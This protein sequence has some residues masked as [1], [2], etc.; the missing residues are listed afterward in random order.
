MTPSRPVRDLVVV[1]LLLLPLTAVLVEVF[2]LLSGVIGFQRDLSDF[3]ATTASVV[4]GLSGFER[5]R[6]PT[7]L[8]VLL[9]VLGY[10]FVLARI[11]YAVGP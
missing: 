6:R 7:R 4:L 3:L 5:L 8:I 2:R 9:C 11:V 1:V 10:C